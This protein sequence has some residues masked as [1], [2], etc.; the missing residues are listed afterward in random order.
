MRTGISFLAAALL[1]VGASSCQAAGHLPDEYLGKWYHLQTSGGI[2]GQ[3]VEEN[4][5]WILNSFPPTASNQAVDVGFAIW[6]QD[7]RLIIADNVYDGF[8]SAYARER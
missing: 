1:S 4:A 5:P 2:Q 6:L 3:T 8:G 7:A